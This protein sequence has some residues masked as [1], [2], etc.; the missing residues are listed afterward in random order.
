MFGKCLKLEYTCEA[1]KENELIAN[2]REHVKE[3]LQCETHVKAQ[4]V[5][6]TRAKDPEI[7]EEEKALLEGMRT[8]LN[9]AMEM[10]KLQMTTTPQ[11]DVV[12][13]CYQDCL[14]NGVVL[15][16]PFLMMA[17]TAE[18]DEC[19][20]FERFDNVGDLFVKDAQIMRKLQDVHCSDAVMVE[21]CCN[22]F[23]KLQLR[24]LNVIKPTFDL[25]QM[26]K[27]LHNVYTLWSSIVK[28]A[29]GRKEEFYGSAM[30]P[31]AQLLISIA[32]CQKTTLPVLEKAIEEAEENMQATEMA[33]PFLTIAITSKTG[34]FWIG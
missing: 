21:F 20:K 4:L 27:S 17:A 26:K 22:A 28:L 6:I 32:D 2:L 1:G 9:A 14:K 31:D 15:G 18:A 24:L 3:A 11:Y 8:S 23:Q 25:Q 30:G 16:P 34:R 19:V 33:R 12:T 5:K 13:S 10:A 7:Y 29:S